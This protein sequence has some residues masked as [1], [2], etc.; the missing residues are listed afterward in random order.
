MAAVDALLAYS[1][2]SPAAALEVVEAVR[3]L[4]ELPRWHVRPGGSVEVS[5][6]ASVWLTEAAKACRSHAT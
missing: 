3:P 1:H 6:E 4:T 2:E 5:L